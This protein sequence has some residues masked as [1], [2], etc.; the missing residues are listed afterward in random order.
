MLVD[1]V[2]TAHGREGFLPKLMAASAIPLQRKQLDLIQALNRDLAATSGP[3]DPVDGIIES[4]EL[5]FRMQGKV[6]ELLD[7]SRELR[8]ILDAYGVKPG[9]WKAET[10]TLVCAL[11][12]EDAKQGKPTP[13][14]RQ[15]TAT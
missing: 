8:K 7:F 12:S 11:F 3:P 2:R 10:G 14:E 9:R 1:N 15:R 6:P 4:Y 13:P 5:G